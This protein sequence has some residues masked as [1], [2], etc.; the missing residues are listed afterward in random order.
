MEKHVSIISISII[1]KALEEGKKNEKFV[2]KGKSFVKKIFAL[3]TRNFS[4]LDS[5][6]NSASRAL[7]KSL[8]L[9]EV[10]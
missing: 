4:S 5:N 2:V 8:G 3:Q 9:S 6:P 1:L 10:K 7:H